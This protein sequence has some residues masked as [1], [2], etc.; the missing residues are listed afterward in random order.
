[1]HRNMFRWGLCGALAGLSAGMAPAQTVAPQGALEINAQAAPGTPLSRLFEA[2]WAAQPEALAAGD[3]MRSAASRRQA[4]GQWTAEAPAVS[5]SAKTDRFNG[6][7]GAREYEAGVA[8]PLWLPGERGR[9]ARLAEAQERAE[10]GRLEAA[11]LRTAGSV[12]EAWWQWLRARAG[13]E[14]ARERLKSA[15][16]L[17]SDVAR[18]VQAG[19]LALV[20]RHQAVGAVASATAAMAEAEGALQVARLGLDALA[21]GAPA[22]MELQGLPL[23]AP[24]M[25][26]PLPAGTAAGMAVDAH[27]AL[28][29]VRQ[30][31]EVAR[32]TAELTAVQQ[33]ANPEL[34][35][36]TTRDRGARG[37]AYQQSLTVAVRIPFGGG[38][39]YEARLA[40]ALAEATEAQAQSERDHARVRADIAAAYARHAAAQAQ[41]DAARERETLAGATR[42]FMQK[43][44]ALGETDLPTRLRIEQEAA[45][46]GREALRAR[47]DRDAAV[48][49]LNQALGF[50]P[51]E[52]GVPLSSPLSGA[53]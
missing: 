53:R 31:A 41:W 42:G 46:A 45:D 15:R 39:R 11:R 2:A 10:R 49:A 14:W 43:S 40:T 48:S 28:A 37:E 1:M 32:H 50:L 7:E 52:S 16:D 3:R 20:D 6:R 22:A 38:S 24:G 36:A 51:S 34:S 9:T 19:D 12:R 35:I 47:L 23:D 44:F 18:R 30:K 26:E 8:L 4:A 25:V 17:A 13:L 21:P 27:P 5:L 29:E 33:R